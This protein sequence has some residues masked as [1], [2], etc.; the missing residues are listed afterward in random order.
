ML[1]I[2]GRKNSSNVKKV[3]WCAEELNIPYQQVDAGGSFGKL[4]DPEYR[5]LN[6]NGLVPTIQDG[7]FVLW[8]SNSILRYLASQYGNASLYP[9]DNRKRAKVEQWMDWTAGSFAIPFRDLIFNLIRRTEDERDHAA[10]EAGKERCKELFTLAD[11]ALSQTPYLAGETFSLADIAFGPFAYVWLEL[12][13]ERPA[14]PYLTAWYERMKQRP[15]F[16][17]IVRIPIT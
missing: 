7:D 12:P 1:K 5:A 3:L 13:I 4:N 9:A 2:W 14:L 8:E 11:K 17:Q 10:L 16:N 15:A 6:P